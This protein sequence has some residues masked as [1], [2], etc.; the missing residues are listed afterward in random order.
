MKQGNKKL[1]MVAAGVL[2]IVCTIV[3]IKKLRE[4]PQEL[5]FDDWDDDLEDDENVHLVRRF[6]VTDEDTIRILDEMFEEAE[7]E[8]SNSRET[9]C[10]R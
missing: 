6:H 1:L 7:N 5:E 8:I 10:G 2:G 9:K 3:A 4:K